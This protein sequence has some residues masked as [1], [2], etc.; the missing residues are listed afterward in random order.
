MVN[1]KALK[2][3]KFRWMYEDEE[4]NVFGIVIYFF[5]KNVIWPI[6]S[7]FNRS[8]ERIS[9]SHA[10][11]KFGWLNYDFDFHCVYDLMNFKLKRLYVCL[12]FGHA[13]QEEEDMAALKEL[14]KITYRLSYGQYDRKYHRAHTKKWGETKSES[15]P[16]YD[17]KGKIKWHRYEMWKDSTKDASEEV[18]AQERKEFRAI[19]DQGEADRVRD[20]SRMAEL[21]VKYSEKWWD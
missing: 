21:L 11:A 14:I 4:R 7:F 8:Y 1:S 2:P 12:K 3:K 16:E 19:Y 20:I 9:R 17:D 15:I 6:D 5:Q 18:K 13:V 10:Y